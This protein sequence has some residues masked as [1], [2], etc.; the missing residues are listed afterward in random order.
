MEFREKKLELLEKWLEPI[1]ALAKANNVDL[2]V[3]FDMFVS[4]VIH[5]GTYPYIKFD[6]EEAKKDL[7]ELLGIAKEEV[8]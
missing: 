4:N 6:E 5:D 1:R 7:E 8:K 2:G 3:A